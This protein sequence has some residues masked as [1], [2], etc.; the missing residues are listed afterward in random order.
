MRKSCGILI[1]ILMVLKINSEISL[2]ATTGV[3]FRFSC[4][5]PIINSKIPML[6]DK[7]YKTVIPDLV[8]DTS[9]YLIKLQNIKVAEVILNPNTIQINSHHEMLFLIM[10]NLGV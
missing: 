4:L 5:A 6:K 8:K 2:E 7:I 10:E 3:E 9:I 1:I